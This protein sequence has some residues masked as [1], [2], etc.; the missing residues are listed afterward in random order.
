MTQLDPAPARGYEI[1]DAHQHVGGL[2]DALSR[3]GYPIG[4]DLDAPT[5]VARRIAAMDDACVDWAVLQPS[6]GYLK[7]DGILDTM[8]LNDRMA[9]YKQLAPSRFRAVLGTVEP[10]HGERSMPE[11]DR[12]KQLGLD[13]LA[14]HHRFQ[15]CYIDS[16][17]M[18]PILE[19]MQEAGLVP[20]VH[21]N[22]ESSLESHWRLQRL[23][24]DFT[25]MTF[26]AMDGLWSYERCRQVL[27][28]AHETPN[29]IWDFG[30]PVLSTSIE[31]WISHNGSQTVC[32]SA[33]LAYGGG[34]KGPPMLL[35]T[36]L[37][38]KISDADRANVLGGNMSRAF[39]I[40]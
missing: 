10:M 31:E 2:A 9:L 25:D 7:A 20:L 33:D 34:G 30:G 12:C 8:R 21:V 27:L 17:W 36:I 15:G 22:V 37:Q 19:R 23:A 39:G 28:T 13:G 29:I 11:I 4:A 26:I 16:P 35:E 18:W 1:V 5:D 6:H 40:A 3:M 24:R 14:W 32:F 38:A